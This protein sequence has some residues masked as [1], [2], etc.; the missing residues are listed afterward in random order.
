MKT[1]ENPMRSPIVPTA[2]AVA[3]T[4]LPVAVGYG[5][6][7]S[8][9]GDFSITNQQPVA[10]TPFRRDLMRQL[11]AWWDVHAYYPKHA[12][13]SDEAGTVK[14]HLQITPNGKIFS[15]AVVESS[16]S[17]T[18]DDAGLSA[19]RTG[20]VQPF[21]DGEPEADLDLSLHYVL[22]HR[23]NDVLP[24]SYTPTPSRAPFTIANDP[25]SSPVLE[26][27][28]Q[29]TCTGIITMN[30]GMNQPWRG[31]RGDATLTFFRKPDGTPWVKMSESGNLSISPA[32]QIGRMVQWVGP[33]VRV[34]GGNPSSSF[35]RNYTYTVWADGPNHLVGAEG[36]PI[37]TTGAAHATSL[38]GPIDMMCD[39]AILPTV[40]YNNAFAQTQII[41]SGDPP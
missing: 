29:R 39:T 11:Q 23:K 16:G 12:S 37:P 20:G 21:P 38:G 36:S 41:P 15:V 19:F 13:N 17:K 40:P 6:A 9:E 5:P 24:A 8:Q 25:V 28:M 3:F 14:I 35:P 4:L 34:I 18:L 22:A 33:I 32:I 27:M 2:L 31:Y 30:G 26:T 7:W 1:G 10:R